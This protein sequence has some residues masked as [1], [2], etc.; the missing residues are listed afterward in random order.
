MKPLDTQQQIKYIIS[1]SLS[2]K[3]QVVTP[4]MFLKLKLTL[5]FSQLRWNDQEDKEEA[6]ELVHSIANS[7]YFD[8]KLIKLKSRHPRVAFNEFKAVSVDSVENVPTQVPSK[9][10][11]LV[12]QKNKY[13]Y[14]SRE[15]MKILAEQLI[16]QGEARRLQT[17]LNM[18][19]NQLVK[20]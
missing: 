19:M 2:L 14:K 12:I 13:T 3:F 4:P 6:F 7:D 20:R 18:S 9:V 16:H 15:E 11:V 10:N 5:R 1:S 8:N 17:K